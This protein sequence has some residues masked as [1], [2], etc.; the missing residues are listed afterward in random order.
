MQ[1]LNALVLQRFCEVF[2]CRSMSASII[3]ELHHLDCR[4]KWLCLALPQ[5]MARAKA[6]GFVDWHRNPGSFDAEAYLHYEQVLFASWSGCPP[7]S[8]LLGCDRARLPRFEHYHHLAQAD[9]PAKPHH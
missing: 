7:H 4:H 2:L 1:L 5:G 9:A 3:A 6:A 8:A